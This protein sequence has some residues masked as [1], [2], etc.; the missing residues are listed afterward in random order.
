MAK[1]ELQEKLGNRI[2]ELRSLRGWSQSDL[3]R[4]CEKD[5]QEA[6]EKTEKVNLTVYTF[7]EISKALD[8]SLSELLE[9]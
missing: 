9:V 6:F 1:D 7:L 2:K 8:L 4:A 3:A 5:M